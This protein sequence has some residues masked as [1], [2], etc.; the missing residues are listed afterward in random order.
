[1]ADN[2]IFK[3]EFSGIQQGKVLTPDGISAVNPQGTPTQDGNIAFEDKK[4]K[5]ALETE[6]KSKINWTGFTILIVEDNFISFKLLEV[7]LRNTFVK[8]LHA[9]N[10][11]KAIDMVKDNPLISLVLMDI[12]LPILNGY[13][14]TKEIKKLRPELPVIAQTANTMD[15]DKLKCIQ[16]GCN[17]YITK[18]IDFA[19]FFKK[20]DDLIRVNS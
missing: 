14:A 4:P 12:Q 17:D 8:I 20:V 1:M 6:I 11:Q 10:G 5:S 15:D 2:D 3:E 19:D 16:A 7:L 18:P 13:L 9:D